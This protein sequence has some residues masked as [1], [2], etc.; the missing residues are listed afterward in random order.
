MHLDCGFMD[1][2][3]KYIMAEHHFQLQ[4]SG[5]LLHGLCEECTKNSD[6]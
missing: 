4:C 3:R 1:E 2:L 5:D 6:L